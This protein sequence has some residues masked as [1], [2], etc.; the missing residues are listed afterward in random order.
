MTLKESLLRKA[1]LLKSVKNN[2]Q[3]RSIYWDL[4]L[5]EIYDKK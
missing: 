2:K 4:P 1:T 5:S 3:I